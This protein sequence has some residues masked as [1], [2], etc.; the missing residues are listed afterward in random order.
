VLC[1][2]A[3]QPGC[4]GWVLHAGVLLLGWMQQPEGCC[5][6]HTQQ[7]QAQHPVLMLLL[8]VVVVVV[9]VPRGLWGSSTWSLSALVGGRSQM[10]VVHPALG[11]CSH[12]LWHHTSSS[13]VGHL[14]RR[15]ANSWGRTGSCKVG[16]FIWRPLRLRLQQ[17]QQV[18]RAQG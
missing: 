16:W 18:A 8:V 2:Q 4:R 7:Q 1:Q 14:Y 5:S 13:W 6:P 3:L 17:Q 9:V 11:S 10:V 15:A 12:P